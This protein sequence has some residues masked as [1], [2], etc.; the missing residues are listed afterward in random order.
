MTKSKL[1][2]GPVL[3]L[4]MQ[5][6]RHFTIHW[7]AAG[8]D[9]PPGAYELYAKLP[10]TKTPPNKSGQAGQDEFDAWRQS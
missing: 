6:E 2:N 4:E 3:L 8:V 1:P 5:T 9:L 7:T 10:T